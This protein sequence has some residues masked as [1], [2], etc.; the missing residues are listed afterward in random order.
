M[1]KNAGK[2]LKNSTKLFFSGV[3]VLTVANLLVKVIGLLFKIPM[4]AELGGEGLGYY[5]TAYQ[6]YTVF[7]M[8]STAGLPVAVSILISESRSRGELKQIKKIFITAIILFVSIG[9][10][11]MCA[12]FFGANRFAD[13]L[14]SAPTNV[15]IMAIAPTLF[16]I[17]V[18]STLR[19]YFQGFQQMIPTAIS[20]LIEALCKLILGV[21]F[22][23]YAVSQG[24]SIN[25]VAAYAALGLSIGAGLGMIY[26]L[27]TKL[28]FN[29]EKYIA[30]FTKNGQYSDVTT[31]EKDILKRVLVIALP[32]TLS[33]TVMSLTNLIDT[34]IVQ[35]LL[36]QT[37]MSQTEATTLFGNY[38][39]LAVP[40]FN[41]P[42]VIVYP[43]S[44]AIVPL[45]S[46]ARTQGDAK[47]ART[48][49]E[50][51]LKVSVLIGIP[52]GLGMSVLAEPILRMFYSS[53]EPQAIINAIPLLRVLAPSTIFVCILS[54]T[55][56]ILQS[57][58]KERLPLISMVAGAAV[59]LA[60]NYFLIGHIGMLAT[61]VS[62]FLCY[63]TV[64]CINFVFIV[65]H[66]DIVPNATRIFLKPFICGTLCAAS[67]LASYIV[68]S[69]YLSL[70]LSTVASIAIAGIIYAILIFL[71]KAITA[72]DIRLLPKG[73]KIASMLKK[74]HLLKEQ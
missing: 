5:T 66:A 55:N 60:T 35:N 30:E 56:A 18:S 9:L 33:A 57:C 48:V 38:T 13:M 69:G 15:C 58:G 54:V 61:P 41:L 26:L 22:A 62:T 40:M 59:K 70:T 14:G 44:A 23:R 3:F 71:L 39:G 29:E 24:Y 63:L 50:S 25:I 11:G 12:M 1:G 2:T 7:F 19:G 74:I 4:N 17:C 64:T 21:L 65:K 37:G 8:I 36:Q 32:I 68:L 42:P 45:L 49:M 47:R 72:D 34:F 6:I 43:I 73:E 16:F 10:L 31:P 27:I 28:L 46:L 20:Q 67:A 51:S 53:G 52:C